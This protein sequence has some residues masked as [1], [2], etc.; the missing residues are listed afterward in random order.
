MPKGVN[1]WPATLFFA[2]VV[3]KKVVWEEPRFY[4][5]NRLFELASFKDDRRVFRID[6]GPRVDLG[7]GSS[8]SGGVLAPAS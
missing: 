5:I 3:R 8:E 1:R 6:V 7:D 2:C 4:P